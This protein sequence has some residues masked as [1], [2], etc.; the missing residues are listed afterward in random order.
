MREREGAG[1]GPQRPG[2]GGSV[3]DGEPDS[4]RRALGAV[5]ASGVPATGRAGLVLLIL[6]VVSMLPPVVSLAREGHSGR[7]HPLPDLVES[8]V[9][10]PPASAYLGARIRLADVVL[11][12]GGARSKP[13]TTGYFLGARRFRRREDL[14][15]GSRRL[16]AL[17]PG[18]VSKGSIEVVVPAGVRPGFYY[19]IACADA[20]GRNAERPDAQRCRSSESRLSVAVGL[21]PAA[22]SITPSSKD[23]GGVVTGGSSADQQFVVTNT[24]DVP[25]GVLSGSL[26]GANGSEFV[27]V[28]DQCSG[29]PLGAQ[30]SCV[31]SVHAA[32]TS[33]G[34]QSASLSVTAAGGPSVQAALS[35]T[36]LR[37]AA[38][39]ITPSPHD[40]GT[41]MEGQQ[42]ASQTFTVTNQGDVPTSTL[43][44]LVP[45]DG[46]RQDQI[47]V[48]DS[49]N[50]ASTILG[51]HATC[52]IGVHVV[53][54]NQTCGL[55][56]SSTLGVTATQGGSPETTLQVTIHGGAC[57]SV[58]ATS[59][60][61][62][63][64]TV[65]QTKQLSFKLTNSGDST[66]TISFAGYTTPPFS[67]SPDSFPILGHS[68]VDV[69]MTF[70]PT[71]TGPVSG[72]SI[73]VQTSDELAAPLPPAITLSGTGT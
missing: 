61:F 56:H 40:F 51:P 46:G 62:G 19:V 13:T 63:S 72:Q 68:T 18:Q 6:I 31:E 54:P 24:G 14:R 30:A 16:V 49:D 45:Q 67:A 44:T 57:L 20:A 59:L 5:A 8:V 23:F 3:C 47:F 15:L 21:R 50:C 35:A 58:D 1:R 38:L 22:L 71:T 26:G 28:S 69:T 7:P 73:S 41:V 36:G 42:S 4:R 34:A 17:D 27:I 9:G 10:N 25:T 33:T 64:V 43:S 55:T 48:V 39:S 65:G 12:R 32:P 70:A 29:A 52:T 53:A 37:P 11:N 2:E 60:D 66:A